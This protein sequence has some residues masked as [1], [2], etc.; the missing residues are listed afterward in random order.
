[1]PRRNGSTRDLL[2]EY[3][4]LQANY[5]V[6]G[7]SQTTQMFLRM[8]AA[9]PLVPKAC[10]QAP[11]LR[12]FYEA[13]KELMMNELEVALWAIYLERLVWPTSDSSVTLE[14]SFTA[15]AAK[16]YLNDDIEPIE[17][18]LN[19]RVVNFSTLHEHWAEGKQ[20][21]VTPREL[22]GKFKALHRVVQQPEEDALVDYN[23]YV[24]DILQIAPSTQHPE[25][26][27]L[28]PPPLLNLGSVFEGREESYKELSLSRNM[29]VNSDWMQAFAE[30]ASLS[31]IGSKY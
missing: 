31:R 21:S 7:A 5:S 23:Y 2:R 10:R 24:D 18:Y 14:L 11:L 27:E 20:L 4:G 12:Y 30:E 26:L 22:N 3:E 28:E 6:E 9:S 17:A 13:S 1:M 16:L 15:F 19:R 29:S 25:E 8:I